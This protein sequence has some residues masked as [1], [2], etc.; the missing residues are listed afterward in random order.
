MENYTLS[1]GVTIPKIGFG[2]YKSIIGD[3]K[4][5]IERALLNGYRHLDTAAFYKNEDAVGE[6]IKN[7][8]IMR[9]DLFLTTKLWKG[10]LG[11]ENTL[12]EFEKSLNRLQTEYLDLYL[13]HWPK[14]DSRSVDWRELDKDTWRA[15]EELYEKG[16]IRAIG[17]SN[18]L[19]HHLM[20]ICQNAKIMPMVDQLEFHPGYI[21]WATVQYCKEHNI[22]VSAWS[23]LGRARVM[24]ESVLLRMAERYQKSIAQ[25]CLRFELQCDVLPLP[26]SSTDSRMQENLDVFDFEISEQDMSIIM[27]LPQIGWSGEHPD[28]ERE[29]I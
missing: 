14:Q 20:N 8:G 13:I 25:L 1:N 4:A 22:L 19:P 26:K 17:V 5:V 6:S 12:I 9:E 18:F 15:M 7:S 16:K 23:P 3:D 11:Y 10:D 2:T 29:T 21:Q 24:N 28:R 27:T